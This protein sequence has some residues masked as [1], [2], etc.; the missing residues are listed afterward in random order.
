MTNIHPTALVDAGAELAADVKIGPFC[1]VGAGVRLAEGVVLE[2]HVVVQGRTSV[3]P[4]TRIFPFAVIGGEP[5]HTAYKGEEVELVIG[6]RNLIREHVTMHP[7]TGLGGG[8]T[9]VGDDGFFMVGS[10]VAHDCLVGD[11]VVFINHAVVGGHVTV[12]D[13]AI[14]GG[15]SAVHQR[16]RVGKHAMIGGM[17]GVEADVIP[18][19]SV[20][21]NRAHLVG[22]NIVGLKRRG[23]SRER[24]HQ[25]RT[26]FRVLFAEEGT[27]AERVEDAADLYKDVPEVMDII[28]F[29]RG[30]SQRG[31][32]T[33]QHDRA[34]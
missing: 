26:A 5:Q 12:E 24:I 20:T 33:P 18:Y 34:A 9:I 16:V 25:M 19:G 21:G 29:I 6:A 2:S 15:S 13:Y 17:T 31:L 22:L 23:F 11:H 8:R 3:G 7:G 4:G 10:H 27:L 14:L 28:T 32:C 30:D 1:V